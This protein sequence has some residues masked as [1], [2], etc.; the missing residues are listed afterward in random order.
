MLCYQWLLF[1]SQNKLVPEVREA[2]SDS[3]I[4][5]VPQAQAKR[6]AVSIPVE[7][8]SAWTDTRASCTVIR[9][10]WNGVP[11]RVCCVSGSLHLIAKIIDVFFTAASTFMFTPCMDKSHHV[12]SDDFYLLGCMRAADN[13]SLQ[14]VVAASLMINFEHYWKETVMPNLASDTW[15]ASRRDC[16]V[17]GLYNTGEYFFFE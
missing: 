15:K 6:T 14:K 11:H 17:P 16:F 7:P 9:L 2:N 13:K 1:S 5:R 8:Q 3:Q 10:G 12:R 4:P